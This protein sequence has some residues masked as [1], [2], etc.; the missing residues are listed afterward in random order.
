MINTKVSSL[1]LSV[2]S[3][4]NYVRLANFQLHYD[5][6]F[7]RSLGLHLFIN[8]IHCHRLALETGKWIHWYRNVWCKD[9]KSWKLPLSR[10]LSCRG[11]LA[12]VSTT[13]GDPVSVQ[14][15]QLHPTITSLSLLLTD[16]VCP[17]VYTAEDFLLPQYLSWRV[18]VA[19]CITKCFGWQSLRSQSPQDNFLSESYKNA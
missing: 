13:A 9:H 4:N 11:R 6:R 16:N 14:S 5:D 12:A 1:N 19:F 10:K 15:H 3:Y 18:V 8:L 7:C 17:H 2:T